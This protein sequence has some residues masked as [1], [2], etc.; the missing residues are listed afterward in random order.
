MKESTGQ[1][2]LPLISVGIPTYNRPE[3]LRRTLQSITNQ[4][5]RNLEIIVSN[6]ASTDK[7]VEA[8]INEFVQSDK[9]IQY[10]LQPENIGPTHNFQ[11]VLDKATAG[12]FI[13]VADDDWREPNFIE[14][15]YKQLSSDNSAVVAFCDFDS[16][17]VQGA[18]VS[19]YPD[20]LSALK[21]MREP[22][23]FLRQVRYFL[24]REGTAKP[25]PIYGLMRR[26]VLAGFSWVGFVEQYGWATTDVLFVFWL[27]TRGRLA[28]CEQRLFGCTV[29]N[30]KNYNDS[31]I[32]WTLPV[33]LRFIGRQLIY[34]CAYLRIAQ[35]ATRLT[36]MLLLPWKL[37]E[38]IVLFAVK[39][40]I[41]VLKRAWVKWV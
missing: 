22:S 13:W 8:V 6:N 4:T 30:E 5:Y 37:L 38:L 18:I 21:L 32:K 2:D 11:F 23:R 7:E 17:D 12:F 26:D 35:G 41:N 15:L 19:G 27:M 24:L 33:Y 9:R 20:F 3:E 14:E 29:G 39:P 16:R 10:F 28:L 36:L 31:K 25:H 34:L 40:G 1:P